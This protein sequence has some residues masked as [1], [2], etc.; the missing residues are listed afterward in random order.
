M[1]I[2]TTLA[3]AYFSGNP[4]TLS[5]AAATLKYLQE[6]RQIYAASFQGFRGGSNEY[7]KM[8]QF[9]NRKQI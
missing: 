8:I 1:R 5:T 3:P 9:K 7:Q 4:L 2:F 6:N